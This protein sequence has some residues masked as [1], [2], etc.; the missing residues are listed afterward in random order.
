[1]VVERHK[2]IAKKI[3]ENCGMGE[4]LKKAGYSKSYQKSPDKLKKTKSWQ[5]LMEKNLPDKLLAKKHKELL[6]VPIKKR[7]YIKGDLE[8]ETE[9]LDTQ[10]IKSGLDMAYKLKGHY[11]AEKQKIEHSG[12]I[13]DGDPLFPEDEELRKKLSKEFKEGIKANIKKRALEKA[14]KTCH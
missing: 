14:K 9:E 3:A 2:K 11:A 13:T 7:T 12:E 10:A 1:M 6:T 4:A 5:E 8:S